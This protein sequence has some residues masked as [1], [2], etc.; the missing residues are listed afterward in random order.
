MDGITLMALRD[1]VLGER[2]QI[3]KKSMLSFQFCDIVE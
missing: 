1:I 2:S 3:Q